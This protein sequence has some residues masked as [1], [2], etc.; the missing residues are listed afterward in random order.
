[1]NVFIL[2]DSMFI[3]MQLKQILQKG[4][5]TVCGYANRAEDAV[6]KITE[7]SGNV[8]LVTIDITMPGNDGIWALQQ[9]KSR[10]PAIRC[11]IVSAIGKQDTVLQSKQYGAE[12][13]IIK[14]LSSEKVLGRMQQLTKL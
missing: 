1:M 11:C 6:Q 8:D 9:I 14:P 10:F 12:G 4:G 3:V 5:Y 2:D 13:Y 7:L